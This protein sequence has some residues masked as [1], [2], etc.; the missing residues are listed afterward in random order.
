MKEMDRFSGVVCSRRPPAV[1]PLSTLYH[2]LPA[3]SHLS[4]ELKTV[5][6]KEGV[7]NVS[8]NHYHTDKKDA[9][10]VHNKLISK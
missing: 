9:N 4:T 10:K 6:Q 7:R 5:K 8:K 2:F 3:A 1:S